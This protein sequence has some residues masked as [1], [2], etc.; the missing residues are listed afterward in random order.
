MPMYA[1]LPPRP[2]VLDSVYAGKFVTAGQSSAPSAS[3]HDV[4][5]IYVV[6][7]RPYP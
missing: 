3:L 6:L 2:V 5:S 7:D 4:G 1:K